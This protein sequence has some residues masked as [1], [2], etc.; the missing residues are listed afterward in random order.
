[1]DLDHLTK[2]QLREMVEIQRV[3]MS[4]LRENIISSDRTPREIEDDIVAA[5]SPH[6]PDYIDARDVAT[7]A[8]GIAAEVIFPGILDRACAGAG[9]RVS[10]AL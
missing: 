8:I 9:V 10:E 5:I 1:M 3:A 6:M 7:T 2:R 4:L